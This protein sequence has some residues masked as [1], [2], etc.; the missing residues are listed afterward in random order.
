MYIYLW[1]QQLNSLDHINLFIGKH[2]HTYA[3]LLILFLFISINICGQNPEIERLID[4]EFRM[5]FPSIYFKHQLTSYAP[6]PYSVDSCIKHIALHFDNTINRL[7]IWK[8][9]AET[10]DLTRK[11]IKKLKAD[12]SKYMSTKKIDMY[13]MGKEQKISRYIIHTA[14]DSTQINYLL[15]LNSVFDISKSRLPDKAISSESHILHPKLWCGNCWK[16]GFHMNKRGREIR[17]MARQNKNNK[18]K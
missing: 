5:N 2:M 1:F 15:S 10:E 3:K 4:G 16:N 6:M 13:S 14:S 12:L 17:K 18:S 9:S 8:D 11:R 7:V